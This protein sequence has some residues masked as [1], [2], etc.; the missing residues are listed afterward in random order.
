MEKF[1][2]E[3]KDTAKL[4]AAFYL[5][6]ES[7]DSGKLLEFEVVSNSMSPFLKIGDKVT[8]GNIIPKELKLGD[9]VVYKMQ[10]S[11]CVHRYIYI[12]NKQGKLIGLVTKADNRFDFDPYLVSIDQFVGKV[13][14][15]KRQDAK[16][17]LE[18]FL[19]KKINFFIGTLSFLQAFIIKASRDLKPALLGGKS[20]FLFRAFW[21]FFIFVIISFCRRNIL[22][23]Y[24]WFIY[25]D[26]YL[27][28]S[29]YKII[30]NFSIDLCISSYIK[31]FM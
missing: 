6:R 13:I 30:C 25:L 22:C 14:A 1:F 19:W 15:I 24:L 28:N 5:L 8:V 20:F 7:I 2:N 17:N 9:I 11:L 10:G 21:N 23:V 27:S 29:S 4:N 16:I 26:Y 31:D 3:S 18:S 12:I